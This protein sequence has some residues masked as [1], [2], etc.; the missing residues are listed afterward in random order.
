MGNIMTGRPGKGWGVTDGGHA[1]HT[2]GSGLRRGP[3]TNFLSFISALSI[4][5]GK[6]CM[7]FPFFDSREDSAE[8]YWRE[9]S[10]CERETNEPT[11]EKEKGTTG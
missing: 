1:G 7:G 2:W 9:E 3:E 6:S 10:T 8:D 5:P 4:P 11:K